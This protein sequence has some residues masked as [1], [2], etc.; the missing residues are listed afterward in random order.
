MHLF[1]NY[2]CGFEE[3]KGNY[4]KIRVVVLKSSLEDHM[5]KSTNEENE[6]DQIVQTNVVEGSVKKVTCNEIVKA[7]Q[8]MKS[9]K[10]AEPS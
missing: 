10:A 6:C 4:G 8:K 9:G 7:M 5:K 2:S 1:K 3:F